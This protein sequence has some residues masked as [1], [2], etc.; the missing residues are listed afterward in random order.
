MKGK[1]YALLMEES[2]L[3]YKESKVKVRVKDMR[4][5][6]HVI[7]FTKLTHILNLFFY[8]KNT[9]MWISEGTLGFIFLFRLHLLHPQ[10]IFFSFSSLHLPLFRI[11][12]SLHSSSLVSLHQYILLLLLLIIIKL[13]HWKNSSLKP[14]LHFPIKTTTPPILGTTLCFWEAISNMDKQITIYE[15]KVSFFWHIF[16]IFFHSRLARIFRTAHHR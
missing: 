12:S 1:A 4:N 9:H 16:S 3:R 15:E 8:S 2:R 5:S 14:S 13:P 11:S 7:G 10:L 6:K